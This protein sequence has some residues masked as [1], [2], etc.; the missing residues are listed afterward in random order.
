MSIYKSQNDRQTS[1]SPAQQ[2]N[3]GSSADAGPWL[4]P[5]ASPMSKVL[6][7]SK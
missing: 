1:T 7:K 5:H 3:D 4:K 2:P 6:L